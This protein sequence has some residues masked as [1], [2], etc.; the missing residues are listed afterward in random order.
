ML[1]CVTDIGS[2]TVKCN[3]CEYDK[4]EPKMIDFLSER[5]GLIAKIKN[6]ILPKENIDELC[7]TVKR[8]KN[9]VAERGEYKFYCFATQ[10][11]RTVSN[12]DEIKSAL[13]EIGVELDLISGEDEAKLSFLGLSS[14]HNF[15]SGLMVDMGG[16]STEFLCSDEGVI[17]GVHSFAFGCLYL[18]KEY[19]KNKFPTEE[20]ANRI[21]NDV[22]SMIS[23]FNL[24]SDNSLICLVGGTAKAIKKLLIFFFGKDSEIYP[25][26]DLYDLIKKLSAEPNRY[27]KILR[28]ILPE[29]VDT[30]IPGAMAYKAIADFSDAK[31]F[32]ISNG[33]IRDGYLLEKLGE[34]K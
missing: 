31:R 20:E 1:Y 3:I 17:K 34:Q 23:D 32:L 6:G 13:S 11:L 28:D 25:I 18:K 22:Y 9:A 29:R 8:Y 27:E 2:N 10:A 4:N 14:K 5:L 12:L 19:V 7:N 26:E 30:V 15:K 24:F 16:A 21:Y 33:G